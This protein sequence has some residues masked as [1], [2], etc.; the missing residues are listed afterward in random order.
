MYQNVWI[1]NGRLGADPELR[2]TA[3]GT[4][5]CNLRVAAT[6]KWK[7]GDETREKTN[8]FRVVI[9]GPQAEN[10]GK[11]LIKGQWVSILGSIENREWTGDDGEKR[12]G[13]EVHASSVQFGPKPMSQEA[14]TTSEPEP[15]DV[16]EED[17]PF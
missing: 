7:Q 3:S 12:Y 8:W 10:C 9:W 4:A 13:W 2:Y 1:G 15:G 14:V 5:V 11:Y 6:R 16:P 17:I